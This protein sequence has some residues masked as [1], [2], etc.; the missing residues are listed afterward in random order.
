MSLFNIY[1]RKIEFSPEDFDGASMT[2]RFSFFDPTMIVSLVRAF[3]L[4][5]HASVK[6]A[7]KKERA[8]SERSE[9]F[10]N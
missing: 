8:G 2:F 6:F 4:K 7:A 3:D 1:A 10:W 9:G 5:T